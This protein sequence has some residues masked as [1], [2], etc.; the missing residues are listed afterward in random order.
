MKYATPLGENVT[1]GS[2]AR[3]STPPTQIDVPGIATWCQAPWNQT[4]E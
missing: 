4:L 3:S 1:H 2:L